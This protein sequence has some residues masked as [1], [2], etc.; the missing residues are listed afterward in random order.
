MIRRPPIST[1]TDTLFPYTPLF[2]SGRERRIKAPAAS[3]ARPDEA[4]DRLAPVD[5]RRRA[6]LQLLVA[7]LGLTCFLHCSDPRVVLFPHI[8]FDHREDVT[9]PALLP[10]FART[11]EATTHLSLH[12]S[13]STSSLLFPSIICF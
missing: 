10:R 8:A 4:R 9:L 5:P 6:P 12:A 2:R 1:R 13:L 7:P 11:R 3:R